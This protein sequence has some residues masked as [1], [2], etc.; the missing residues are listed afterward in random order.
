MFFITKDGVKD[1]KEG[2][3]WYKPSTVEGYASVSDSQQPTGMSNTLK[4]LIAF[5]IV[6]GISC[7]IY[8]LYKKKSDS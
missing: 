5:F 2:D 7:A 8:F 6:I 4:M 3:A 1:W